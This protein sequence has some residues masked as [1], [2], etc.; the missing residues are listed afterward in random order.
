ML[1]AKG[2]VSLAG[3]ELKKYRR[4]KRILNLLYKYQELSG[5]N[6]SKRIGVSLPTG[7][8]LLKELMDIDLVEERGAGVSRG[9]RKPTLFGISGQSIYVVACELGRYQGKITIYNAHNK[10]VAPLKYFE[11]NINDN[12]LVDKIYTNY[13][14]LLNRLDINEDHVTGVGVSMPGLIDQQNGN[15]L[16]IK[17][18]NYRNVRERLKEKFNMLVYLNN[19]AR[20]QAYGEYMFGV[21][22]GH[23]NAVVINWSYGIGMGLIL[24][25]KLYDGSTGFSG[26]LSHVKMVENGGLC[27]CGKRGCLETIT[28]TNVLVDLALKGIMEEKVSQLTERFHPNSNRLTTEDIIAAAKRGDEFSISLLSDVGQ[29]LGKGLAATIQ[30]LNPDIIVIG[31]PVSTANQ[32]VLT[33][34]Q[35]ALNQHCLE[36]IVKNTEV[37]ISEIWEQSGLLG[38]TAMLFQDIFSEL[39]VLNEY[40]S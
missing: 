35:Q 37:K 21:A 18:K 36:Q 10:P 8:L 4:K 1:I 25:G 14:G 13:K 20:M 28:S 27:I 7:I 23:K 17:N 2:K 30:I 16:T 15:N 29:N 12:N 9:G 3:N 31:G 32:F 38:L 26:E 39:H 6:I 40:S 33:P 24:N 34:I 22:S 11:A 5:T 19:D